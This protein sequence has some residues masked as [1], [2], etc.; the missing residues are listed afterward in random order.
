MTDNIKNYYKSVYEAYQ[1]GNTESSYYEPIISLLEKFGCKARNMSGERSGNTGENIDI[2]LWHTED[3]VIETE[4][5]AGIEVKKVGGIDARAKE[6]IISE[7]ERYGNVILTD[8]LT[9]QFWRSNENGKHS[10]V[11]LIEQNGDKLSLKKENIDY[12]SSLVEDFLL[13]SPTQIRSSNKLAEYMAM[14]ARSIRNII[15]HI[16]KDDGKGNPLVNEKQESLQMFPELFVLYSKIKKELQPAM[17]MHDFADMYAQ[18]IV[19]GLF[20]ARYNDKTPDNFDRYEA[21]RYLQ[22]ESDLLQQFFMH[23]A[24]TRKIDPGLESVIDKL[25]ALYE[26]CNIP[27]L[28][29]HDEQKDTIIHFYEEFLIYYDPALRKS[30]GVFYTPVQA[31]RYL[32]SKVD[33]IL[34]EDFHIRNGL[35]N[36]ETMSI[37][38]IAADSTFDSGWGKKEEI[39]VPRV[40]ILD[41]ACGTGSFGAEII[42]YIKNTYYTGSRESFYKDSIQ[43]KTGTGILSRLIGFEIMMTSYVVARLKIRRTIDETLANPSDV[44]LPINIFLTNTLAPPHANYERGKQTILFDFSGAITQEA[45]QADTWK[46]RRP[47]KVIIGNPPYLAASTNIYDISA[48]KTETDGVSK[49]Q[50][51]NPKWLGDDYVKFF[52]FSQGIIDKTGEGVLAFVSNNGYLDNATFRGMRASLLRSFDKIFIVNLHGSANKKETAPGGGKD[53]NIFDIMQGVSL[54][55]GVKNT[56]S[57]SWAKVYYCDLWGKRSE[58]LNLLEKADLEFVEIKPDQKM[59]LLIP[60][61]TSESEQYMKGIGLQELFSINVVGIVTARDDL[62]IQNT[63]SDIEKI[64]QNFQKNEVEQLRIQYKLG[65]DARDWSVEG[66]KRDI[67]P[68]D[69][70]ITKISY[71]PFDDRYTYYT[72]RSKGFLCMPRG[73]VMKHFLVEKISPIGKNIGIVYCKT[74]RSFFSPFVTKNIITHRLFS[75][76]C[77]TTYVAPLYLHSETATN[78][79]DWKANLNKEAFVQLTEFLSSPPSPIEVFDYIYGILHDPIYCERYNEFLCRDFPRVPVI[80]CKSDKDNADAFYVSEN[81]FRTYVNAGEHLRKLHQMEIETPEESMLTIEPISSDDMEIGSVNYR[82]G[83]LH[84]NAKKR[85]LG[86][87]DEVWKYQIGGYQVL[88]KWLKSHKGEQLTIESFTH[89]ENIVFVIA[90]TIKVQEDLRSLHIKE[91][92]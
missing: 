39:S 53:E 31:V 22:E 9:W 64:L 73:G 72:G 42:R 1:N 3:N 57:Q 56:S 48:Y 52:R 8:N 18:T 61:R 17:T 36:N 4:P 24:G 6:Q 28:L 67:E 25:C 14:H 33:R 92:S 46:A 60:F 81:M 79:G 30:L 43:S 34:I 32:V 69:G 45:Y 76:M 83:I 49:L 91:K 44:R 11:Q 63:M 65:K 37:K 78:K 86:I 5:F 59:A 74:S 2:K 55:I 40:A 70:M 23:I 15:T 29:G 27:D 87:T 7:A 90:E 85:I 68:L 47:I 89:V 66:A 26:I 77:E 75:A 50:E 51:K 41:P 54:F 16:L 12:F 71:R 62:C 10:D 80:N 21:I 88:D 84:I 82:N 38:V 20:I 35:S 58:K 13:Q 19:Y